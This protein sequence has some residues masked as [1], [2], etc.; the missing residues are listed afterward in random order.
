MRHNAALSALYRGTALAAS[1]KSVR[2][3]RLKWIGVYPLDLERPMTREFI[4]HQGV[5]IFPLEGR[6]YR[7]RIF[8]VDRDTIERNENICEKDIY[9]QRSSIVFNDDGLIRELALV[10]I[11][12]EALELPYKSNYPI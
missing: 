3:D 7:I 5:E 4:R 12:I 2:S 10:G 1:V 11:G 9:N 6:A 8:E